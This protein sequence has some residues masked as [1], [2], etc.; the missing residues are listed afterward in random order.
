MQSLRS[1]SIID[2]VKCVNKLCNFRFS[3]VFVIFNLFKFL[4]KYKENLHTSN[5]FSLHFL[6]WLKLHC[7]WNCLYYN[8]DNLY[9]HTEQY[10]IGMFSKFYSVA[11]VRISNQQCRDRTGSCIPQIKSAGATGQGRP[12]RRI[13][14]QINLAPWGHVQLD[15]MVAIKEHLPT[16]FSAL[17]MDGSCSHLQASEINL[18]LYPFMIYRLEWMHMTS[19]LWTSLYH[20]LI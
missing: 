6:T 9:C 3:V 2:G 5:Y 8:A 4:W 14:D 11:G 1:S 15:Y 20:R 17:W 10:R 18:R 13:V 16:K 7:T 19:F 12:V